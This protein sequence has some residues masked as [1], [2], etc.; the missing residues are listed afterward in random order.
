MAKSGNWSFERARRRA[1]GGAVRS[2]VALD[3]LA[4]LR[5]EVPEDAFTAPM[6]GTERTGTAS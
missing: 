6:L 5:A 1:G 2:D 3:S 4:M